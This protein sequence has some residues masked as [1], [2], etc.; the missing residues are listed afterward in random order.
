MQLR[1]DHPDLNREVFYQPPEQALPKSDWRAPT[2]SQAFSLRDAKRVCFDFETKDPQLKKMGPGVRRKGNRVVGIGVAIEDGPRIYAPIS[3]AGGDNCDWD[4]WHWFREEFRHYSGP[5][6]LNG[7]SYDLDWAAEMGCEFLLDKDVREI[8]ALDV[9]LD[10]NH[11]HY[12]L[13]AICERLEL[14]GKDEDLLRAAA[15]AY[16]IDPKVDL[17]KLPA[18]FV[19]PYGETDAVR[20]MQ[21]H[22][23]QE[24]LLAEQDAED[25]RVLGRSM[26]G[27]NVRAIWDVERRVTALL[28]K[29]RRRGV[30]VDPVKLEQ[31]EQQSISVETEE[32][33]R[34]HAATGVR[35]KVGDVW[36]A[37]VLAHA[38][39]VAG[40][41]PGKTASGKESI[42]K[43]FL[44]KCGPV[45]ASM[46]RAREWSKLRTTFGKQVRDHAIVRPDDE[47]RVHCSFHQLR[48]DKSDDEADGGKGVRYGRL[49][50]SDF[51]FQQQPARHDEF[52]SLWRTVFLPDRGKKWV[53]CDFSQQEPRIAC[54]YAEILRLP[55]AKEFA[56]E[57][58][59]NPKL[60]IHSKLA[61]ISGI[62]RKIVKNH[63]NGRLYGMGDAKMCHA[64]GM[65]TQMVRRRFDGVEREIEVAGPEG[66]R[67]IDE[68]NRYA[69]WIVGL[70]RAAADKA[71]EQ[72]YVRTR[73]GR[74]CRFHRMPNGKIARAHKAFNRIGQGDAADAG[75]I[76]LIEL[77]RA[78]I[79]IQLPVHDEFNHSG[80]EESGRRCRAIM[81]T[82]VVFNVP[83][84]VDLEM[85]DS[86]GDLEK[87]VD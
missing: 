22:R 3:H 49:S 1:L 57:Y 72:G 86:W 8:Q 46:L 61:E 26:E 50:S 60:D 19:G 68:F 9:L 24:R 87:V 77:E 10:E 43:V 38:L 5:I 30:R 85:G 53:S 47:W 27:R 40:F 83:M 16:R 66:R 2:A 82:T 70:C 34:I 17:W 62:V 64:L 11:L 73:A 81:E 42:D 41:Q 52:G 48:A 80:D 21:A 59:R 15:T 74:K 69:P 58:R 36:K 79:E 75:K 29:M 67:M 63:V 25:E 33:N 78:G 39:R 20:P 13:D 7:G 14:P 54:H 51:N 35:I 84:M 12:S 28:V 55:G 23:R 18:R 44:A 37:D 76:T 71:S 32:L 4:V 45:G 56:D 6:I 31:I 65:P